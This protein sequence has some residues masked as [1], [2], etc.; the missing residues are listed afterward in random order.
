MT[1]RFVPD[2]D[3]GELAAFVA[4]YLHDSV[5]CRVV[6]C[7]RKMGKL[8]VDFAVEPKG[9]GANGNGDHASR[10]IGKVYRGDRG[11]KNFAALSLLWEA[12]F[13]PP[14]N[15]TVVRPVAYLSDC[16]LLLQEKAPGRLV[17]NA[18]VG[19]PDFAGDV[20]H[21]VARWLAALH[22]A[23]VEAEPRSEQ[24]RTLVARYGRE[25]ADVLPSE[26]VR[27]RRLTERGLEELDDRRLSALCPTHGD[28]HPKNIFVDDAGRLTVIDLDTFGGQEPAA[29]VAYFLAHVAIMGHRHLG[30]FG[31]TAVAR[32]QLLEAYLSAVPECRP[33]RIA[34]YLGLA[35]LQSLYYE[36]CI[37][38]TGNLAMVETWLARCE[39]CLLK[40]QIHLDDESREILASV[41]PSNTS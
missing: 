5:A 15:F 32:R 7:R 8:I 30:S 22:S 24:V 28:F 14:S 19:G 10:Y 17:A 3:P 31:V 21:G 18:I 26:R 37:L 11:Q 35:F 23:G 13:R 36:L 9:A 1:K 33:G 27:L 2:S 6:S 34:I 12:G 4:P 29:D 16:F 25:V 41:R 20:M 38:K 39:G 40:N